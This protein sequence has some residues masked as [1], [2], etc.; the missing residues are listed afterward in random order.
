MHFDIH[1][2]TSAPRQSHGL[3]AASRAAY[4][5]IPNL[6][7]VMAEAPALLEAYQELTRIFS[8]SSLSPAEQQVVILAASYEN[9]CAYCVA[10]HTAIASMAKV[11]RNVVEALRAGT[12]IA[13]PKLQALRAFT[14]RVV[15]SRGWPTEAE[16]QAFTGAGFTRANVLEVVL[17]VGLKTLSNYAN[18]IA[19]T[20][21]DP[22]FARFAWSHPDGHDDASHVSAPGPVTAAADSGHRPPARAVD[23]ARP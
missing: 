23:G 10:A 20:P 8:A 16:L 3:L 4:G 19:E 5:A 21:L 1:T 7:G 12:A 6:H 11:P 22:V 9:N 18:H 2:E 13:D 17:G 14:A 15:A